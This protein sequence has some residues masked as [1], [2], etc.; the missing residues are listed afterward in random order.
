MRK[1]IDFFSLTLLF[2]KWGNL[3]R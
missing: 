2:A 3:Q 1:M